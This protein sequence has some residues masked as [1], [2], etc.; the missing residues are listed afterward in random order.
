MTKAQRRWIERIGAE[1][2]VLSTD[3]PEATFRALQD[4]WYIEP[5]S[6]D[7]V[8]FVEPFKTHMV[9]YI[10]L[11]KFARVHQEP[12]HRV[13]LTALGVDTRNAQHLT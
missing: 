13:R 2:T 10:A 9:P 12:V 5:V 6:W 8:K 7:E 4:S 11:G 3:L 1:G